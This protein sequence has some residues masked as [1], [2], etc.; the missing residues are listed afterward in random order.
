MSK[1][2]E[3]L[4]AVQNTQGSNLKAIEEI[5]RMLKKDE[6]GDHL[7]GTD[8][9]TSIQD[10]KADL[11]KGAKPSDDALNTILQI[12]KQSKIENADRSLAEDFGSIEKAKKKFKQK[13]S[14]LFY[15]SGNTSGDLDDVYTSSNFDLAKLFPGHFKKTT[16]EKMFKHLGEYDDEGEY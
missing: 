1:F 9:Y 13:Y 15:R 11:N 12:N 6:M 14:M 16:I 10:I 5:R 3:Y 2:N 8:D 4:E 7:V